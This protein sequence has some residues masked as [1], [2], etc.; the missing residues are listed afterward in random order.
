MR[1]NCGH[2][3]PTAEQGLKTRFRAQFGA[4]LFQPVLAR[5]GNSCRR[6]VGSFKRCLQRIL[7]L[8]LCRVTK[9]PRFGS[10]H[11][12]TCSSPPPFVQGDLFG[13]QPRHPLQMSQ[14]PGP[15]G[16]WCWRVGWRG[17]KR[18]GSIQSEGWGLPMGLR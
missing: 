3:A 12:A 18:Q 5:H 6:R 8:T 1:R 10:P 14:K 9:I 11:L 17:P 7:K 2:I 4:Q 15:R 16:E 13:C